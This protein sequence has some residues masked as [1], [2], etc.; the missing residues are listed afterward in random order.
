MRIKTRETT[1]NSDHLVTL[2]HSQKGFQVDSLRTPTIPL[3]S[4]SC[5]KSAAA[6]LAEN[7]FNYLPLKNSLRLLKVILLKNFSQIKLKI[8]VINV[9]VWN[10]LS[11]GVFH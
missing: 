1:R 10:S 5:A 9:I 11:V 8:I 6:S 2:Y 7:H 4:L 3:V